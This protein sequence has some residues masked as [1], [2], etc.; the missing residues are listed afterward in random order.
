MSVGTSGISRTKFYRK[1]IYNNMLM[2]KIVLV[3]FISFCSITIYG[4]EAFTFTGKA[5]HMAGRKV[6][7]LDFFG[8]KNSV[9][10]TTTV[11]DKG[12]F[13][14]MFTGNAPGGMYRLKFDRGRNVDFIY[15]RE[16]IE[17]S[18][19]PPNK[20]AGPYASLNDIEVLSSVENRLYYDFL[21][22]LYRKENQTALLNQLK[23][24]YSSSNK[25]GEDKNKTDNKPLSSTVPFYDQI[26]DELNNVDLEF[27]GYIKGF[28][29]KN[30]DSY[31]IKII[32]T[33]KTPVLKIKAT[34]EERK[35]WLKKHFWGRV[36]L[37][38][39]TLLRSPVVS[40]KV[41]EYIS[42]YQGKR[43]SREEQEMA[44]ID[45]VDVI[46]FEAGENK[47]VF[48]FVLDFVTRKFREVGV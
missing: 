26:E 40:S 31:A 3:C 12:L 14:F 1:R 45:A 29:D 46:L 11:D 30:P 16:D 9:V 37:A 25:E 4:G 13:R 6:E 18:I 8:N 43:L 2:I 44:F 35:E 36:D 7:M 47:T 28:M 42:I 48:D 17:I 23:L 20:L 19:N 41:L 15:N 24:F 32:K 21:R 27:E 33:L 10:D 22:I 34:E 39:A 38:D 5:G